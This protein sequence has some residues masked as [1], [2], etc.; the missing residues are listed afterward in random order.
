MVIKA[1]TSHAWVLTCTWYVAHGLSVRKNDPSIAAMLS[2]NASTVDDSLTPHKCQA[3]VVVDAGLFRTGTTSWSHWMESLGYRAYHHAAYFQEFGLEQAWKENQTHKI[4]HSLWH[5]MSFGGLALSDS[6]WPFLACGV[7]KSQPRKGTAKFII[8]ERNPVDW[9]LSLLTG[10]CTYNFKNDVQGYC[11]RY[12]KMYSDQTDSKFIL[13]WLQARW[14]REALSLPQPSNFCQIRQQEGSNSHSFKAEHPTVA[15][16]MENHTM[17]VRAC[18][19][20]EDVVVVDLY[21]TYNDK[22]M[23]MAELLG[24]QGPIPLFPSNADTGHVL[25]H[26]D[27]DDK[28]WLWASNV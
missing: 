5:E 21:D 3:K 20:P 15:Q 14:C 28:P 27:Y 26:E 11:K 10:L 2:L 24:C 7:A 1:F 19:P 9:H 12:L 16:Y 6:P 23:K 18:V 13:D 4:Y 8:M 22:E 25:S 17:L